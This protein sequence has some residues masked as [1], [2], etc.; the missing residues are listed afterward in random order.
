[1]KTAA[2]IMT[3][4]VI[5]FDL[6]TKSPGVFAPC[7]A[8]ARQTE[9]HETKPQQSQAARLRNGDSARIGRCDN[10]GQNGVGHKFGADKSQRA[11]V[12]DQDVDKLVSECRGDFTLDWLLSFA[13]EGRPLASGLGHW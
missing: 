11:I 4:V 1:M 6:R 9:T 7:K 3:A 8:P 10:C 5:R 13:N 12:A 2:N